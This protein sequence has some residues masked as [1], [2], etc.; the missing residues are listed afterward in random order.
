MPFQR[1]F[2]AQSFFS[3]AASRSYF[4]IPPIISMAKPS[5]RSRREP[6]PGLGRLARKKSRVRRPGLQNTRARLRRHFAA[7]HGEDR[8]TDQAGM[9]GDRCS[10]PKPCTDTRWERPCVSGGTLANLIGSDN[11]I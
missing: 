3:L 10:W 4:I 1:E 5:S 11:K 6:A 2:S 9:D 7:R 8:S